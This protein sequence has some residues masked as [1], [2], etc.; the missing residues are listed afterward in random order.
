MI[1]RNHS[2][3][4]KTFGLVT[5]LF[6]LQVQPGWSASKSRSQDAVRLS[7]EKLDKRC[8]ELSMSAVG[9]HP[10]HKGETE[11]KGTSDYGNA[12]SNLR[13]EISRNDEL[14]L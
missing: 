3:L 13:G 4:L 5:F 7:H 6:L 14:L 10:N 11:G 9:C 8:D 1:I 2:L 12:V